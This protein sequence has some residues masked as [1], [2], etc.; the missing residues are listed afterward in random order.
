MTVKELLD[1]VE[2][3]IADRSVDIAEVVYSAIGT[4]ENKAYEQGR[5]VGMVQ[6]RDFMYE[7]LEEVTDEKFKKESIKTCKGST[8]E[9]RQRRR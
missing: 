2:D 3:Y 8:Q 1:Y 6:L 5:I 4:N 9:N 7:K